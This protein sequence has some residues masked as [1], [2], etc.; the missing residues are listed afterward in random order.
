MQVGHAVVG[1]APHL[2]DADV[3]AALIGLGLHA[4]REES[5]SREQRRAAEALEVV[6]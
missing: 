5:D 6:A 2:D 4:Q 3:E 1:A